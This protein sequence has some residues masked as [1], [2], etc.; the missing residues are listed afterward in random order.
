M[1]MQMPKRHASDRGLSSLRVTAKEIGRRAR[2]PCPQLATSRHLGP[3]I[4]ITSSVSITRE[5]DATQ[6]SKLIIGNLELD[7]VAL[8]EM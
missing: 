6:R 1:Q 5:P 7:G 3:S 4:L 8:E 2:S